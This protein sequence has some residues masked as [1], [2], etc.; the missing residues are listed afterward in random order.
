MGG[1]CIQLSK[2]QTQELGGRVDAV[3][4]AIA[5]LLIKRF[6]FAQPKVDLKV[7]A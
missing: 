4:Q 5:A 6:H 3:K 7:A 2:Q 1:I